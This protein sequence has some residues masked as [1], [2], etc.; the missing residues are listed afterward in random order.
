M[1]YISTLGTAPALNFEVVLL[2]GL[3][4]DGGLYVPDQLTSF[5]QEQIRSWRSLSY[6]ELAAEIVYP[7]VEDTFSRE[8]LDTILAD[9][10]AVFRHDAIA[11]IGR[12]N[13]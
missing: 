5:S 12:A 3:A 11:Q 7:F 1:K 8:E 13:G 6:A 10:Y 2:T 4:S 9:T